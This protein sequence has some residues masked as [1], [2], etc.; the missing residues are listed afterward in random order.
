M[1]GPEGEVQYLLA[2]H[3]DA[4]PNYEQFL[5]E[6]SEF[7]RIRK[8]RDHI[9]TAVLIE[10][11]FGM[12][13][14]NYFEFEQALLD[15]ALRFMVFADMEF[16]SIMRTLFLTSR[17]VQNLLSSAR[18]Y[19]DQVKHDLSH[20]YGSD[21]E[22]GRSFEAATQ[23]EY[24]TRLG[25]RA[26]E[27]LRNYMQHRSLPLRYV[28]VALRREKET[29]PVVHVANPELDLP[30][31]RKHGGFKSN[32]LAQLEAVGSK[33]PKLKLLMREYVEGLAEV[34]IGLRAQLAADTQSAKG[35]HAEARALFVSKTGK[36][37]RHLHLNR[38]Y[39]PLSRDEVY[40]GPEFL[41]HLEHL[42]TQYTHAKYLTKTIVSSEA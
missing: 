21:S 42:Q 9:L 11:K 20:R 4:T 5:I 10:E 30:D 19:V 23:R 31:I 14:E 25:Y 18:L 6:E 8:A 40:L 12:V 13:L 17:R 27:A 35:V 28:S 15:V 38:R 1:V 16:A 26:M 37:P 22:Q 36:E 3:V 7:E 32:V 2:A 39:S 41:E 34:H 24:D 33:P 29:D